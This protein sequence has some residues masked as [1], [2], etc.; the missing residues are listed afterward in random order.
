MEKSVMQS[1]TSLTSKRKYWIWKMAIF[2][3]WNF[4]TL[5]NL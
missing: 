4:E 1:V 3:I 5:E 2:E